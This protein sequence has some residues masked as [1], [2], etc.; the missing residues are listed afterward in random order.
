MK[1]I[2]PLWLPLSVVVSFFAVGI[3]YWAIPYSK[4]NLPDAML[5]PGLIVVTVSALLLRA[6]GLVSFWR[7]TCIIGAS[8]AMAVMARV[9]VEGVRDPT[10]HN[11]WPIEVVIAL[12]VGF[13]CATSGAIAGGLI[14]RLLPNRLG[15]GES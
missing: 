10:S 6:Y 11:L 3:P 15:D 9:L 1:H 14:A 5:G 8:V 2:K 4:V 7:V 12:M 13:A